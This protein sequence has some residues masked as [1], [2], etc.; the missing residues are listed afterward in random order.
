MRPDVDDMDEVL[1]EI[2][3]ARQRGG[4]KPPPR[5]GRAREMLHRSLDWLF[6]WL[7]W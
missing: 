1:K 3:G 4:P 7:R 6:G 2:R 5:R